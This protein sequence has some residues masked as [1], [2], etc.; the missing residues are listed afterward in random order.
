[1]RIAL[2][3]D[4]P[5]VQRTVE[6]AFALLAPDWRLES[7]SPSKEAVQR[8]AQQP[9]AAV[10]L[11]CRRPKKSRFDYLELL[12]ACLAP[13][14]IILFAASP[15]GDEILAALAAGA[16]GCVMKIAPS[17]QLVRAIREVLQ[18]GTFLCQQ[19]K[20]AVLEGLH[21]KGGAASK[22]QLTPRERE[23]CVLALNHTNK[24]V[25]VKLNLETRTVNTL[26]DRAF[27]KLDIHR[28]EELPGALAHLR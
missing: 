18:E 1:M 19:A 8:L 15:E 26:L 11:G 27:K 7:H 6:E 23:I 22:A 13:V 21:G 16:V 14:P 17:H 5:N 28:R 12:A 25:A 10:L 9:P 4:D 20:K 2:V 3:D 24:E